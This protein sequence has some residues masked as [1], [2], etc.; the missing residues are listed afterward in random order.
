MNIAKRKIIIDCDPG[1]DDALTIALA[2]ARPDLDIIGITTVAGNNEIQKTTAN[3][4]ITLEYFGRSEIPVYRGASKPLVRDLTFSKDSSHGDN[5]LGDAVFPPSHKETRG[6]AV[7]FIEESIKKY[8]GEITILAIGPLTNIARVVQTA[9]RESIKEI[10]LMNGAFFVPGNAS[11]FAEFNAFIDPE[12]ARMV[13]E[14]GI[15][16]KAVGLDITHGA[17]IT[18]EEFDEISKSNTPQAQFFTKTYTHAMNRKSRKSYALF[19]D[20]IALAWFLDPT[21]IRGVTGSVHVITDGEKVGQTI[22]EEGS[23]SCTIGTSI[24]STRFF[25]Y[26]FTFLKSEV[27]IV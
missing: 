26:L 5:G 4:L 1:I 15:P 2:L 7:T 12:A 8:P 19:W 3:A 10:F 27:R 21:L 13:Y 14:S 25:D 17:G 11:A 23:G 18:R 9:H 6:D 22:F 20:V 24:D 16:I